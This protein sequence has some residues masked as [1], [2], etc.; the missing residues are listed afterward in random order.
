MNEFDSIMEHAASEFGIGWGIL[1]VCI[2][3][4]GIVL[5]SKKK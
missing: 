4:L 3:V 1:F 2:V 5:T